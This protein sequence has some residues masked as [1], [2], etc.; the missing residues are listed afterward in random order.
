VDGKEQSGVLQRLVEETQPDLICL[1]E[2]GAVNLELFKRDSW[3][4]SP[5]GLAF[6]SVFPIRHSETVVNAAG[7]REVAVAYSVD[8]PRGIT[9]IL[10]VHLETPRSGLEAFL[11]AARSRR[12][13]ECSTE[14]ESVTER[15]RR[16]SEDA[17]Q[18]TVAGGE[19][20]L[21]AGDFNMPVESAIFSKY[22][23]S[24][25]DAF[26]VAGFGWGNT[27]FTR[28]WGVRIDHVLAGRAWRPRACWVGPDLGSDH[29]P[30]L[31][32]LEWVGG[33]D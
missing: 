31:A 21:V 9:R 1:Q 3:H 23:S 7:W 26:T 24:Y 27:K 6:A 28:W 33:R 22:W 30:V 17:V 29:R 11:G 13:N 16:E 32:E 15:R 18:L 5:G 8:T 4:V 19:R 14:M 12:W 25:Q 10:N 20:V 2:S